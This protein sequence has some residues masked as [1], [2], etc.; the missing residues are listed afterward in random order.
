MAED[1]GNG[2]GWFLLGLGMGA[3]AGVLFAPKAGRELRDELSQ[4][5]R[6][7]GEYIK[8]KSRLATDQVNTMIDTGRSHINEYVDRGKEAIERGRGQWETYIDKGRE[9]ISGQSGKVS[10]AVEAGKQAYKSSTAEPPAA[11]ESI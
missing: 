1:S 8:Q 10:A 2:F 7:S 4:Q 11:G 9:A 3:A 6:D 5:A